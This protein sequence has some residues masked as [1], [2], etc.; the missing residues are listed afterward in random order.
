MAP[1]STPRIVLLLPVAVLLHQL[2]E[3]FGGFVPWMNDVLGLGV[4]PERFLQINAIGLLL[5]TAGALAAAVSPRAAWIAAS[6]ASLMA[7]NAVV[8]A[9]LT[10]G[11]GVY[12]P[13]TVTGLVIYLPLSV[14]ALRALAKLLSGPALAGSVLLGALLHGLATLAAT[15]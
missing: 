3:W 9:L 8:H 7:L 13:G 6:I 5:F 10:V 2:E 1:K 4:T 14:A 11:Y 12:S 15:S